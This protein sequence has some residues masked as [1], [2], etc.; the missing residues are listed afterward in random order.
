[1]VRGFALFGILFVHVFNF[2]AYSLVWNEPLDE[3]T[4]SA[5]RVFFETKSWRLFSFLFGFGFALQL[6]RAEERGTKFATVYLR[7]LIILFVI[8]AGNM[9]IY[10]GDILMLYAELGLL[11]V[12]FRRF[13]PKLLLVLCVSLLAV[14]PIGRAVTSFLEPAQTTQST[15]YSAQIEKER[16][17]L[18]ELRRTH[19]YAVGSMSE[20]L[21]ANF[22]LKNPFIRPLGPES[23]LA[24][25][26]MFLLG[27][28]VGQ[29]RIVHDMT[30]HM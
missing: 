11:L 6:I 2:G 12:L 20:V 21:A 10:D 19:V 7:R 1:M 30:K 18:E 25:F 28:Y 26:A 3:F 29:R 14:F 13:P 24:M 22:S 27:L 17:E 16:A 15:D 9:E 4:F 8:G 5:M 23:S